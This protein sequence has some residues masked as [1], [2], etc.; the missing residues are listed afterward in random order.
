MYFFYGLVIPFRGNVLEITGMNWTGL[1]RS[2]QPE[3]MG[4]TGGLLAIL[5]AWLTIRWGARRAGAGVVQS[6]LYKWTDRGA[7]LLAIAIVGGMLWHA[8]LVV[9][10][11]RLSRQDVDR[12]G[13]YERMEAIIKR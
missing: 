7:C 4:S 2:L 3:I 8:L 5:I 11:N 1:A 10:I 13:V 12:S 9:S 6:Q